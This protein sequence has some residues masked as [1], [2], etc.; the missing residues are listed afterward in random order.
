MIHNNMGERLGMPDNDEAEICALC[1]RGT[2]WREETELSIRQSTDRGYV[3]CL[4]SFPI[5]V[6][7]DCGFRT[8]FGPA[9]RLIE[10]A[11][12]IKYL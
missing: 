2:F 1:K 8:L 10:D 11:I 4:V 6:C 9:E 3:Q 5:A 12:A 7:N